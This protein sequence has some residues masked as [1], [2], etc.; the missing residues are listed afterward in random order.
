MGNIESTYQIIK[1]KS[2]FDESI[3]PDEKNKIYVF[4]L[5]D[6]IVGYSDY[7]NV[8]YATKELFESVKEKMSELIPCYHYEI[9]D[10]KDRE[11]RIITFM[12]R[13][14]NDLL[15]Y[16]KIQ[17]KIQILAVDNLAI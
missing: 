13:Y 10:N 6:K 9:H 1:N 16:P 7:S 8:K 2:T 12:T 15:R 17:D 4:L 14:K 11:D 5:N 3:T